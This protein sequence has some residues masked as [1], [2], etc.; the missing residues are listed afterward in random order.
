MYPIPKDLVAPKVNKLDSYLPLRNKGNDFDWE[1]VTG[2]VLGNILGKQVSDY[3]FQQFQEGCKSKIS[4]LMDE[5]DF[6]QVLE[7]MYFTDEDIFKVSPLFLLFKAPYSGNLKSEFGAANWRMATLF[8]NL[9]GKY[10]CTE[11]LSGT[12]NFLESAMLEVLDKN[13]TCDFADK[14][15]RERAYLPYISEAFQDDMSFLAAHPKYL[16]DE[17]SNTLKL[18]SFTYCAQLAL[19]VRSWRD[20]TPQS[21]PLYFI[22]DSEKASSERVKIRNNGYR[23]FSSTCGWLFPI[24]SALEVLQQGQE[25]RPLWQVYSEAIEY[26]DQSELLNTL[27]VYLQSFIFE[28]KLQPRD[29]CKCVKTAFAQLQDVAIEQFHVENTDRGTVNKKYIA[30][31]ETQL[32]SHFVQARGRAGKVLVINPDMLLL[33]T[34]LSIGANEKLRL[35]EL[36]REFER[37]GFY[38]DNQSQQV[39]VSFYERM[40]NIERMSDSGDAVYVRKTV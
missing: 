27:N 9:L 22:L 24:L 3:S 20:G 28:R 5:P 25:K 10:R 40:G 36:I 6:W 23:V 29:K 7:R 11:N 18:Y 35:H 4:S 14:F 38:L 19:N 15:P 8:S 30:A 37:R 39:L 12:L 34:N 31:L 26:P 16:L 2:L 21:K 1:V 17:L 13:L 33:L 32:C